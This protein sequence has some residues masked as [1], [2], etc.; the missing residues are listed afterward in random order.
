M[1][2][3]GLIAVFMPKITVNMGQA[4]QGGKI[5]NKNNTIIMIL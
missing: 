1:V 5:L 4:L 2:L 3:H